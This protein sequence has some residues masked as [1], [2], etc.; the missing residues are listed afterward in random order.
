MKIYDPH[1]TEKFLLALRACI[2]LIAASDI[3]DTR[4]TRVPARIG[5]P[6]YISASLIRFLSALLERMGIPCSLVPPAFARN[7]LQERCNAISH[8]DTIL[9][10]HSLRGHLCAFLFLCAHCVPWKKSGG[11]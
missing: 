11:L 6:V 3:T 4:S 5:A 8:F 9:L 2:F 7:E 10:A 1:G